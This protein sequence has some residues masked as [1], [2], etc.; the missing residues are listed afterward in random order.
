MNDEA[1]TDFQE[2]HSKY[3]TLVVLSLTS[4]TTPQRLIIL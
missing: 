3:I 4:S 2:L 1:Y